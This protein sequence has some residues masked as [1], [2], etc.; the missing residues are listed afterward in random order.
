[1]LQMLE[2]MTLGLLRSSSILALIA[3]S[4]GNQP[5]LG[6]REKTQMLSKSERWKLGTLFLQCVKKEVMIGQMLYKQA[7]VCSRSACCGCGVPQSVQCE[8]PYKEADTSRT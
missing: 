3:S 2:V 1:M 6:E 4:V 5:H 7:I 8:L